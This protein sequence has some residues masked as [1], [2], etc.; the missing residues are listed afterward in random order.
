MKVAILKTREFGVAVERFMLK[1]Q[2]SYRGELEI[3]DTRENS[4]NRIL[5]IARMVDSYQHRHE[6]FEVQVLW[7]QADRFC[8]GGFERCV[9]DGRP[10]DFAQSWICST[11]GDSGIDNQNLRPGKENYRN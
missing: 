2:I 10:T 1:R 9:R 11:M 6:L 3:V 7:L 4:F 8:L 5:R